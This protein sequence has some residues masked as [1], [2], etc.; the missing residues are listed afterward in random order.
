MHHAIRGQAPELVVR[1]APAAAELAS[2]RGAHRQA[3][4]FLEAALGHAE[5]MAAEEA[6]DLR[7][8]LSWE[9]GATDRQQ[10]ALEQAR[11]ALAEAQATADPR[12]VGR[13]LNRLAAAL[14]RVG[15]VEESHQRVGEA[16]TVLEPLGVTP[17]LCE[18]LYSGGS[19][20]MLARRYQLSVELS[21]RAVALAGQLGLE[22][23][24]GGA[25]MML[26]TVE[27]VCGD[28]DRGLALL[29]E[30]KQLAVERGDD[31]LLLSTLGMIGS[32][33]GEVRR[34][35]AA[36]PALMEAIELGG[37]RDED[38]GVAYAWAWLARI[39]FEQGRWDEATAATAK[40]APAG[41][42]RAPISPITAMAALGRV[43][44]RRGDPGGIEVL[45]QARQLGVGLELQHRWPTLA[46]IAEYHWLRGERDRAASVVEGAGRE[47]SETDSPWGKGEL[48]FWMWRLGALSTPPEGAAPPY[49]LQMEGRWREAAAAWRQIGCPYEEALALADGDRDAQMQG[50]EILDRLGAGPAAAW[51]RQKLRQAGVESIPRGPRPSTLADPH[52][53]TPRQRQVLELMVAGLGNEEI[54]ER[55]FISRKTVEH[56]VSAIFLR[57]GVETRAK[58]IAAAREHQ[59]GG[60][61]APK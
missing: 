59:H 52:G 19:N 12:L 44:V 47:A 30:T 54:A 17:E 14:W 1:H 60:G 50:L 16:L 24:E 53:L 33:A 57:L 42:G 51:L 38:F 49:A 55:L 45:E 13:A 56:H 10:E 46:G 8:T 2:R 25:L 29:E 21:T 9:L 31:R 4:E 27:L 23:V 3:V 34:Y 6:T 37:Q 26:G 5:L 58:A 39:R 7:I 22:R 40:V 36:V 48:G 61:P 20:A 18:A 15:E 35:D 28:P 41:G 43:R 11:I 32:G